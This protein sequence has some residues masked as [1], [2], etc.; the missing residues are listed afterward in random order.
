[1]GSSIPLNA[2]DTDDRIAVFF[3]QV[4]TESLE[5][6]ARVCEEL[7]GCALLCV[8][9]CCCRGAPGVMACSTMAVQQQDCFKIKLRATSQWKI[10]HVDLD[11]SPPH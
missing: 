9:T 7:L 8:Q 11:L 1:M 2:V 5:D 10:Y 3:W 4:V 6:A